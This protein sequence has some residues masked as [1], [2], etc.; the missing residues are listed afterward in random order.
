M[1]TS[2]DLQRLYSTAT[3]EEVAEAYA[4]G[5][6]AYTPTAW[7][8]IAAEFQRR[9]LAPSA[10]PV[11]IPHDQQEGSLAKEGPAVQPPLLT[12]AAL[13]GEKQLR[14]IADLVLV[15]YTVITAIL[16]LLAFSPSD[17]LFGVLRFAFLLVICDNLRQGH[18]WARWLTAASTALGA[19]FWLSTAVTWLAAQPLVTAL[20][21]GLAILYFGISIRLV[22]SRG[23]AEYTRAKATAARHNR[24]T[25]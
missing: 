1:P 7:Q 21:G 5:L 19:I 14:A 15:T 20:T 10:K 12:P 11:A 13:E 22:S 3:D 2:D 18:A 17:L 23:I 8:I 9:G 24:A 25:A 16:L 4:A 6:S